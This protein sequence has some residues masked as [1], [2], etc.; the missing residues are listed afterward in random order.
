MS[1]S[2]KAV[3]LSYAS[4]DAEAARRIADALRAAGVEVWFDQSEL[5]GG[6]AWDAKI[7]RQIKE[8]A[9]LI[10]IISANTQARTEGYFRL[11]WRLADQR[12]H[13]MAKGRPFLLPVV[14][15]DT[16]DAEAQVPDS[17]TEV[18][19]TKAPGGEVPSVF[20]ARVQRLLRGEP[21]APTSHLDTPS[22][23]G[24]PTRGPN[25]AWL[26]PAVAGFLGV[27]ALALWQPWRKEPSPRGEE[28][29]AGR[30]AAPVSEARK[31]AQQALQLLED[32]N[33][34]RETSWLAD[35]LC[36]RALKLDSGDAEVWAVAAFASINLHSNTYDPTNARREKA[37][38]Q[39]ER[40]YQL[41]PRSVQAG[42][43]LARYHRN[44][45]ERAEARRRLLELHERAPD[46]QEVLV[47]LISATDIDAEAE[48]YLE[49]LR[50]LPR[51]N[52]L[53]IALWFRIVRLR[54][55]TRLA[56]A[57]RIAEELLADTVIVRGGHYEKLHL[58]MRGWHDLTTAEAFIE[59]LPARFRQEPAFGSAIAHYWLWRGDAEKI[60]RALADVPQDYFEEYAAREAKGLHAGWAHTLAGR[61]TAAQ[62]EWRSALA[63]VEER[64]QADSRSFSLLGQRA[65]LLALT[66]QKDA[67]REAWRLRVELGGESSRPGIE[68]EI[69]YLAALGD[70]EAAA[71]ILERAWP[72]LPKGRVLWVYPQLRHHPAFAALRRDARVQK[73]LDETEAWLRDLKR[74]SAGSTS[75]MAPA[76]VDQK[77]VAVLAFANLSDDKGSEYFSDGIS[78]ELLNVLA[79]VPGLKVSARTSAFYFKGRNTPIPEIAKQLGVAYVVEGSVQ[80][81]G[82]RVK[83]TA[84]LIKAADGF[85]VWSNSFTRD[86]KDIFAVQD[87]IA[88]KIATS[89]TDK[90]GMNLPVSA[91]TTP[92]AYTL[93]LQAR[94]TLA[95]RGVPNLREAV[96][97]FDRVIAM[98]PEYLPARSGLAI[99]LS[100][101]PAWSRSLALG[102]SLDMIN[103]ARREARLVIE[104]Q[105]G[106]AEAWSALGYILSIYDWRWEEAA[107]AIA[108]SL[109]LAPNDAEILNFAGDYYRM[110]LADPQVVEAEKR[111][112]ELNPLQSVNHTDLSVCYIAVRQY[113]LA[114][115]PGRRGISI[116]PELVE[117][118]EY[119]LRPLGLLKRFEEMR[120]VLAEARSVA[121]GNSAL[122][123]NM[124]ILAAIYEG[125]NAEALQL[126]DEFRPH[127][128]QGGYS[129]AEYGSHYLR[130]GQPEKA[131][132]WLLRGAKGHDLSLIDPTIVDLDLVAANPMTR[133][134]LEEPG[135]KE[136]MEV[137]GRHARAAKTRK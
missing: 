21:A 12:T 36:E 13:L 10:P 72:T 98:D 85:H 33:F 4:Q 75:A 30:P 41:D 53:R 46:H 121:P 123:A 65:H 83:I 25:R 101:I 63:L 122:L 87:E 103:R 81:A 116:A 11:E 31:L 69:T 135:L 115:E 129:P 5:V 105:P 118:Y 125:R 40:A 52:A 88:A 2:G 86:M 59:K 26:I 136:L 23:S 102:E 106:N 62:A 8:C 84:Q 37:R 109:A 96:R 82:D 132:P 108:R 119:L 76:P 95:K 107:E 19:W 28:K 1:D 16:R 6:D 110:V 93:Y 68:Q 47:S 27:I 80:R 74:Q 78:E 45:G 44:F 124:E 20:A 90:L 50:Q 24:N 18:Q 127:V 120:A 17:F 117:N 58:L 54:G 130:L 100:L 92:E 94:S 114:I 91:K 133:V 134:V 3:F 70:E 57:E 126:L 128:E 9:L 79:K 61:A 55:E 113:E 15:D 22:V 71:A 66:G 14:I 56:E 39:A 77:S 104:R 49:K 35:E 48:Q 64:L 137:R 67:A 42:L 32:P 97:M 112:M 89:L 34:T 38:T 43:A 131:V 111:A 29:P 51:G 7:R 99:S 73:I 60:L